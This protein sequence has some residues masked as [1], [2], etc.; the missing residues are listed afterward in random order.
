MI[1]MHP[2]EYLEMAYVEPYEIKQ[3]DLAESLGI[4]TAAISRLLAC[5]SDLSPEMAV[6]LSLVFDRSAESWMALQ[7]DFSLSQ[8]REVVRPDA[9]KKLAGFEPAFA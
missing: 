9:V 5:K 2:G 8:A 1:T 4:S 6:R 7:S 3:A